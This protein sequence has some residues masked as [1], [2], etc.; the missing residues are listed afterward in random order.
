MLNAVARALKIE[1]GKKLIV[2]KE[3]LSDFGKTCKVCS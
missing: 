1:N 3:L 2:W